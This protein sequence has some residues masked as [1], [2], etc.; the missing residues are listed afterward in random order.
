MDN[1]LSILISAKLD[2]K[3]STEQLQ[4]Q[5]N[6]VAKNLKLNIQID[7][8]VL[9][10]LNQFTDQMKR[11]SEAA[12]NTG[13]VIEEALMPDGSKIKRTY[14]D[15]IKGEFA[16]TVRAAQE[17]AKEQL[18]AINEV[19]QGWGNA[20]KSVEKY[21]AAQK[22]T[23]NTYTYQQGNVTRTV[24]T[25]GNDQ[26]TSYKDTTN[27]AKDAQDA[28]KLV[29]A[30]DKV[31]E[32]LKKMYDQ[33]MLNEQFFTNFNKVIDS[34][35]NVDEI[36]KVS[37]ALQ[38]VN[39][40]TKNQGMQQGLLS[41]S[42]AL[43]NSGKIVDSAG[44]NELI[45]RLNSLNVSGAN[46]T[47]E[48]S[49]MQSQLRGFQT[50]ASTAAEEITT[51]GGALKN[52]FGNISMYYGGFMLFTESF[53]A[54]KDGINTINDLNKS[55]T[56]ISIVTYQNQ[57]QVAALGESYNKLASQMGVTTSDITQEATELYRQGLT[58]DQVTERMKV[59]TEYAK[60]SSIDTKTASEIMTAAINSMG[61]SAQHA[62]D[63]WAYL[64]DATAT[65]ASEIGEA[66]QRVGGTAG[67]LGV[68]FDKVSSWI[69][70][71]S[72][73]T[74]ESAETI[75]N[76]VKSIL[77]R[78]ESLKEKGFDETDGTKVNT[79]AK[80]LAQINVN[81]MD[82]NGQFRNFGSVM[83]DIGKKWSSLDSKQR[84]YIATTVA[85]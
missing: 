2:E 40:Y 3:L 38:R 69:A 79:V 25:N 42:Q 19:N 64:G 35:K 16:E 33:G 28:Q 41:Q 8:K 50:G 75:G 60:I 48:L 46:A 62:A 11:I 31:R 10:T 5:L 72:S 9:N 78:M 15:G 39:Q 13:K 56:E 27:Y 45:T 44:I 65:D 68:N 18:A 17:S 37:E 73:R 29:D 76:S 7:E 53:N 55:L 74:R 6:T 24:N 85:G 59:I 66:M 36:N 54:L 84:A 82:S 43:L 61:V 12:L 81:L 30:Q 67:A 47:R 22:N 57:Q 49:I 83:D 1:N 4:S 32:S 26:V 34:K 80:A 21:N 20:T 51:L 23:N 70:V 58:A 71:I 52:A 63:T 77:A 14:F